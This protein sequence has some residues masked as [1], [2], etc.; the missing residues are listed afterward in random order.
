MAD[1]TTST[2]TLDA[3]DSGHSNWISGIV[4]ALRQNLQHVL[5][6]DG[7][8][9]HLNPETG[10]AAMVVDG[11]GIGTHLTGICG[12][13]SCLVGREVNGTTELHAFYVYSGPPTGALATDANT[14][15]LRHAKFVNG[16]WVAE[17]VDGHITDTQG[18]VQTAIGVGL[19]AVATPDGTIEVFYTDQG[20]MNLRHCL[21][22]TD[23][24][25]T[26]FG[27]LDGAGGTPLFGPGTGPTTAHIGG[28]VTAAVF[29]GK[30]HAF[31]DDNTNGNIRWAFREAQPAGAGPWHYGVLDGNGLA[32][33]TRSIVQNSRAIV[34]NDV[35]SVVYS[36]TT[37][38]EIRHAALRLG[39][40]LWAFEVVDGPSLPGLNG[41]PI[42]A[43]GMLGAASVSRGGLPSLPVVISYL[44]KT[45]ARLRAAVLD[46]F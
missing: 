15:N 24:S 20:S 35:L 19:A 41:Y 1:G 7:R 28:S 36:D 38:W 39:A 14:M 13:V 12:A 4:S 37:R 43:F 31:Y 23:G 16:T 17:A 3:N 8:L 2:K 33:R 22:L 30:V 32:G 40:N 29:D 10:Q 26:G 18:R 25:L 27:V 11:D 42:Q 6:F 45:N 44:D 5:Y 34:W 9:L 21:L 46:T